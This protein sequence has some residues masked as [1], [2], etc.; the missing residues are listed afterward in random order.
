VSQPDSKSNRP[1]GVLVRKPRATIY[2]ALLGVA[3]GALAIGCLLLVLELQQYDY[4][5]NQ[6]WKPTGQ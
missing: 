4:L 1:V 6:P 5:W 2:V 3:V